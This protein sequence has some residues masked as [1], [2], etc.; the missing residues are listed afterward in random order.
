[1]SLST[2]ICLIAL[3]QADN[4]FLPIS[5]RVLRCAALQ[6]S[7]LFE[8][9]YSA[10]AELQFFS[11]FD[12]HSCKTKFYFHFNHTLCSVVACFSRDLKHHDGLPEAN[13]LLRS[14]TETEQLITICRRLHVGD[15][16]VSVLTQCRQRRCLL[17]SSK[18]FSLIYR[19]FLTIHNEVPVW[20]LLVKAFLK[21]FVQV[22][23]WGRVKLR[24]IITR[25]FG[26]C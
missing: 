4:R 10:G 12:W 22:I 6:R 23:A 14:C 24:I 26:S 3:S 16:T 25:G 9:L 15:A 1:M 18:S 11:N 17:Q 7:T 13:F 5:N 21:K 8:V 20:C 19:F 2:T